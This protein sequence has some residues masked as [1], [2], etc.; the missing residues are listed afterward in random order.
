MAV[1]RSTVVPVALVGVLLVSLAALQHRWI[2]ELSRAEEGRMREGLRRSARRFAGD[3]DREVGEILW[4]LMPTP[5]RS[6]GPGRTAL[7]VE[8]WRA[9]AAHPALLR[10]VWAVSF[11]NGDARL[12]RLDEARG[13]WVPAEE[14]PEDLRTLR[15]DPGRLRP[16]FPLLAEVPALV[17]P[18]FERGGF[19]RGGPRGFAELLVARLDRGVIASELLPEL[20]ERHFGDGDYDLAV[21]DGKGQPLYRSDPARPLDELRDS[22]ERVELLRPEGMARRR[23]R[24][25]GGEPPPVGRDGRP[26]PFDRL[27]WRLSRDGAWQLLARHTAGSL[28]VAVDRA[29]R[30]NL[31]V[32]GGVLVLLGVAAGMLVAATRRAE[33]LAQQQMEF[34]A[35]VTHELHT[36]LAAICSA[37]SNLADGVVAEPERVRSYGDM[38]RN[39]GRRLTHTV[40]QVLDFAGIQSGERAYRMEPVDVSALVDAV[41]AQNAL[42]LEESGLEVERDLATSLPL[43]EADPAALRRAVDN[44]VANAVRHGRSGGWLGLSTALAEGGATVEVRVAD[45][46]DGIAPDE[47][48]RLFEPFFRGRAAEKGG[49]GGTGLGLSIVRHVAEAHGGRVRVEG[50]PGGGA[51]FVL[52]LPVRGAVEAS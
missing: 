22:D 40:D 10:D 50:S 42:V 29:R 36:P 34:V 51:R 26:P 20:A 8:L 49:G 12:E 1:S 35:G 39:E 7:Q 18:R 11:D 46:G 38:I 27:P 47:R 30:R 31:A 25:N 24:P 45:R 15:D 33:R 23:V 5:D 32:S 4:A 3:L 19:R 43:V 28:S 52:S 37:G 44:L 48:R 9:R 41:L 16:D 14:W 6:Q 2:G 21:I 13:E 17:V